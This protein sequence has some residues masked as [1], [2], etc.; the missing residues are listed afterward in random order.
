MDQKWRG[1]AMSY[2]AAKKNA[3]AIARVPD[4]VEALELALPYLDQCNISGSHVVAGMVS[5]L[6]LGDLYDYTKNH[7]G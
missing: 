4:M 2:E 5:E 1:M 7:G 3:E 6:L